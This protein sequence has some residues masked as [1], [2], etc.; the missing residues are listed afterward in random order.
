MHFRGE[1]QG[2]GMTYLRLRKSTTQRKRKWK[3]KG[4][5][6]VGKGGPLKRK[7]GKKGRKSLL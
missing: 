7:R 6:H 3:K 1:S 5:G 4:W 2:E